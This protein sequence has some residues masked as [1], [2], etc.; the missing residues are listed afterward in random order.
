MKHGTIWPDPP[1]G[2]PRPCWQCVHFRSCYTVGADD[3]PINDYACLQPPGVQLPNPI[4]DPVTGYLA[5]PSIAQA[6]K[7]VRARYPN[8]ECPGFQPRNQ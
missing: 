7:A 8:Q 6:C 1:E 5:P 2:Y 3:R 4:Y